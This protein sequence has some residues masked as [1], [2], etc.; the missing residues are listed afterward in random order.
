MVTAELDV[1][2]LGFAG[3]LKVSEDAALEVTPLV[4]TS[5]D[6]GFLDPGLLAFTPDIQQ[7]LVRI[8]PAGRGRD[9]GGPAQ[10]HGSQRLPGRPSRSARGRGGQRRGRCGEPVCRSH[11]RGRRRGAGAPGTHRRG[12]V[13]L[14]VVADTDLLSDRM[15]AQA[16]RV[17]GQLL[18]TEFASNGDFVL[19]ALDQLAE[20]P[21]S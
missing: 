19:N 13:Q 8:Q 18:V 3:Y 1:L 12:E 16:Q 14:I 17:F 7:S 9:P 4:R 2:N 15:W 21:T 11:G 5:S 20:V 10:R 6:A